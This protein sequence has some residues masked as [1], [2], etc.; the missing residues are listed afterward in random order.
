M[1]DFLTVFWN[2]TLGVRKVKKANSL[3]LNCEVKC[4]K[5]EKC[6]LISH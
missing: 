2:K 4:I 5:K 3:E 6:E 1:T